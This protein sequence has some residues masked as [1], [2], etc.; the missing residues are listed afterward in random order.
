M[1]RIDIC[2]SE[3]SSNL[4]FLWEN[5]INFRSLPFTPNQLRKIKRK[6]FCVH[7][8]KISISYL[9]LFSSCFNA[10]PSSSTRVFI[11]FC[12]SCPKYNFLQSHHLIMIYEFRFS[13]L[14][15]WEERARERERERVRVKL[16]QNFYYHH[17]GSFRNWIE[18]QFLS[19]SMLKMF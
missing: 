7:L 5:W 4:E 9:S 1:T 11:F 8:W 14:S 19:L 6:P 13:C 18:N 3:I 12:F 17:S 10:M 15:T 16:K 2:M